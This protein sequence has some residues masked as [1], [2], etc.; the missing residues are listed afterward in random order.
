MIATKFSKRILRT[1][2][3]ARR[4]FVEPIRK[5][6]KAPKE[7]TSKPSGIDMIKLSQKLEDQRKRVLAFGDDIHAVKEYKQGFWEDQE[8]KHHQEK[9]PGFDYID[10]KKNVWDNLNPPQ[11]PF[12]DN[13][14]K[15]HAYGVG[16]FMI[17]KYHISGSVII[18]PSKFFK[19]NIDDPEEIKPHTL[20]VFSYIKPRPQ[21][22]VIGTG[23]SVY[24]FHPAF[25]A[26]FASMGIKVDVVDTF[27]AI[28]TFNNCV[29]DEVN[30]ACALVPTVI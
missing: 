24:E 6:E 28:T 16:Q 4:T 8:A 26:H 25:K 5:F 11:D 10:W 20:E 3:L 12:H 13:R 30:V 14:M 17:N 2:R 7:E 18:T 9:I 23:T 22:I 21:Y 19:W 15:V 1:T 27:K 29:D